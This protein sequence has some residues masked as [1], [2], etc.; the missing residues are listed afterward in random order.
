MGAWRWLRM[1]R[2][3]GDGRFEEARFD[4]IEIDLRRSEGWQ[5]VEGELERLSEM[6]ELR[7]RSAAPQAQAD[8]EAKTPSKV[9]TRPVSPLNP[10]NPDDEGSL[11]AG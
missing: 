11:S 10:E 8:P 9:Y 6:D 7:R 3:L 2:S 1:R 5:P 4:R